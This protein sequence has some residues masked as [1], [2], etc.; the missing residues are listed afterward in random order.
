MYRDTNVLRILTN[1]YDEGPR[2]LRDAK[3]LEV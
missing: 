1:V 3:L 2:A